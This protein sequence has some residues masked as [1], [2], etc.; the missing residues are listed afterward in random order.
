MI[1]KDKVSQWLPGVSP[2]CSLS[3]GPSGGS[4]MVYSPSALSSEGRLHSLPP[5]LCVSQEVLHLSEISW[6]QG[7][8]FHLSWL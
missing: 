2:V 1:L 5:C 6:I 3:C 7:F 4:P 8:L